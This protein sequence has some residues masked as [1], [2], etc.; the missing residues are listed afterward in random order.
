MTNSICWLTQLIWWLLNSF[1]GYSLILVTHSTHLVASHSI[2]G[3]LNSFGG[4]L[5]QLVAHSSSWWLRQ[6]IWGHKQSLAYGDFGGA[7]DSR[8]VLEFISLAAVINYES[9]IILVLPVKLKFEESRVY[10]IK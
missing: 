2:G 8:H 1:G 3:S 7:L 4:S 9:N 10:L 5:T 6:V